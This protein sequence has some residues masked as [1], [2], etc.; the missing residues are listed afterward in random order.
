MREK[1]QNEKE[2]W[3]NAETN[4]WKAEGQTTGVSKEERGK[5]TICLIYLLIKV[6]KMG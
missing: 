1:P 5:T 4:L 6:L 3:K 2:W